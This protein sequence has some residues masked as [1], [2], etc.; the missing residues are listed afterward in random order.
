MLP[1]VPVFSRTHRGDPIVSLIGTRDR[2]DLAVRQLSRPENSGDQQTVSF[3]PYGM[4][5]AVRPTTPLYSP[6]VFSGSS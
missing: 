5:M 2:Y 4:I 3:F 1:S 6:I